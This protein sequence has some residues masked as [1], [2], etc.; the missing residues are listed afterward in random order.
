MTVLK[1]GQV[2]DPVDIT[3]GITHKGKDDLAFIEARTR[4]RNQKPIT[5]PLPPGACCAKCRHWMNGDED[6]GECRV[7]FMVSSHRPEEREVIDYDQYRDE[8]PAADGLVTRPWFSCSQ[9]NRDLDQS[10]TRAK[11][12]PED[13]TSWGPLKRLLKERDQRDKGG[14]E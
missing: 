3:V 1:I 4:R 14:D 11:P 10:V 13:Q 7:A 9:F 8:F 6:G 5:R 12:G 2:L